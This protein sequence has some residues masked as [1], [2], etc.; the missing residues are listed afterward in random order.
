MGKK[1]YER[2][3]KQR[4]IR[5]PYNSMPWLVEKVKRFRKEAEELLEHE[6][7]E[8]SEIEQ[9]ES[10][11]EQEEEE[12]KYDSENGDELPSHEQRLMATEA[13]I[14]DA[15]A[16]F[17]RD[18]ANAKT[19]TVKIQIQNVDCFALVDTGATQ[20]FIRDSYVRE[21]WPSTVHYPL[22]STL[23]SSS[24]H[25]IPIKSYIKEQ[26]VVG[27]ATVDDVIFFVVDDS[28]SDIAT[29]IVLSRSFMKQTQ[30]KLDM[31]ENKII[32]IIDGVEFYAS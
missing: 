31:K 23:I 18:E 17:Y 2:F 3:A 9:D 5:T 27:E 25:K 1:M 26:I 16:A 29:D 15:S 6:E 19:L 21:R 7:K 28:E 4:N 10:E 22:N 32:M 20:N 14:E 13:E 11:S 12:H 30:A 24:N 8:D